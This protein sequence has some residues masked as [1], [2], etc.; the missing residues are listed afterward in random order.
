MRTFTIISCVLAL[1]IIGCE[2]EQPDVAPEGYSKPIITQPWP[3]TGLAESESELEVRG[4]GEPHVAQPALTGV[5]RLRGEPS[6]PVGGEILLAED[7]GRVALKGRIEGLSAGSYELRVHDAES[8][9]LSSPG[10]IFSPEG[11]P[12]EGEPAGMLGTV[13]LTAGGA[14]N[15]PL[16]TG[17]IRLTGGPGNVVGKPLVVARPGG[18]PVACGEIRLEPDQD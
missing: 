18:K 6:L 8:C 14:L 16:S 12:R 7:E 10:P 5:A 11:A 13:R 9:D 17:D 4:G 15:H 1:A 3:E 2:E